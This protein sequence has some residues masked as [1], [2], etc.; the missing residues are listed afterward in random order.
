MHDQ[1]GRGTV[2]ASRT[3]SSP[4]TSWGGDAPLIAPQPWTQD[5]LCAKVDPDLFFP[6]KSS[7]KTAQQAKAI[8]GRCDARSDC[9]LYALT[10]GET[11]GIW[12]GTTESERRKLRK[13]A[14]LTARMPRRLS[15]TCGRGHELTSENVY[16]NKRGVRECRTCGRDR[17]AA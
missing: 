16:V 2:L 14:G 4:P 6:E 17:K 1:N 8:C 11:F 15:D 13:E 9:L 3:G 12:G 7:G 5:A 10:A